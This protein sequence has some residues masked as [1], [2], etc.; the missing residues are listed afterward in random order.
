V[1]NNSVSVFDNVNGV[2]PIVVQARQASS[3]CSSIG[4][5]SAAFPN[6]TPV[7]V[8]GVRA[9]QA[10]T[11]VHNTAFS[12]GCTTAPST[13]VLAC[14]NA[15]TTIEVLGTVGTGAIGSCALPTLP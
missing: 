13:T 5:N 10:N 14:R 3:A 15:P 8:V 4:G 7:G 1:T 12:A 9:R 2:T 11:A 6:G